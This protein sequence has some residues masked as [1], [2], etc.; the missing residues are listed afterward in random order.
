[1]M[2]SPTTVFSDA[3]ADTLGDPV[4]TST[5]GPYPSRVWYPI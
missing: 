1:M 2:N 5:S 3:P 4:R